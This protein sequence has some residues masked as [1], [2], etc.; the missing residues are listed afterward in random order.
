[1]LEISPPTIDEHNQITENISDLCNAKNDKKTGMGEHPVPVDTTHT[2]SEIM[3]SDQLAA[4]IV[5][6]TTQPPPTPLAEA[7]IQVT[8][9]RGSEL[10]ERH[11]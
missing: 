8:H 9:N 11:Q 5:H 10:A 7:G 1:M 2:F 6:Q 4:A 3:E